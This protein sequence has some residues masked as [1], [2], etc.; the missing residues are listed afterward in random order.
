[1]SFCRFLA[2]RKIASS[3]WKKCGLGHPMGMGWGGGEGGGERATEC[4]KGEG[5]GGI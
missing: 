5:G 1:M 2:D 4:L 3:A